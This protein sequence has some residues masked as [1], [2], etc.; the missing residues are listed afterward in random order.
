MTALAHPLTWASPR[1]LW[2]GAAAPGLAPSLLRFASDD[3]MDQLLAVLAVDPGRLAD[4][5]AHYET[6]R[7][8]QGATAD[9]DLIDRVPLAEPLR[10]RRRLT[11][12]ARPPAPAASRPPSPTLKLYQPGHQRYY[13]ACATLACAIPG[14][15]DRK[16][17]G[18]HEQVGFVLRRL[19]P[20]TR[21]AAAGAPLQEYAFVKDAAGARWQRVSADDDAVLAPGEERLPTF[22]L[23]LEDGNGIRRTLWGGL[24]PVGRREDY[25]SAAV[26]RDPK[27]LAEGQQAALAGLAPPP[28]RNSKLART[29]EFRTDFAEG[30]KGLIQ[31]AMKAASDIIADDNNGG[32]PGSNSDNQQLRIRGRNLQFQTHSWLLLLDLWAFL[33]RHLPTVATA[34][35]NQ[36]PAGLSGAKLDLYNW[37]SADQSDHEAMAHGFEALTANP[38]GRPPYA[39]SMAEALR[40]LLVGDTA[41][42][43]EKVETDYTDSPG[44]R[45]P[46]PAFHYLLAGISSNGIGGAIDALGAFRALPGISPGPPD[47]AD[48]A[49][50]T[51]PLTA[52]PEPAEPGPAPFDINL[53]ERLTVLVARALDATD[54]ADARPLPFAQQVAQSMQDSVGDTGR[55]RLR[56]VHLNE[57]CGPLHPPTLSEPTEPFEL[58]SFFDPDAPARPVRIS[59]PMDTSPA[60]LRKH[61][62]GTAFVLSNMLCGQVQRA[63]GHGFVDL[64]RHVLPWPL[65]KEMSVGGGSGGCKNGSV[66]IGMICSLSIPI[67]TLCALILLLMIVAVLDF[68]FRWL[69]WLIFCFPVPGLKGKK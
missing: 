52:P 12:L 40:G 25:M 9:S 7:S 31:S 49:A 65:H 45:G 19:M 58:A 53:V 68:I 11:R 54:E 62:R 2:R 41:A 42:N 28:R 37:L 33:K 61:S 18:G 36:S 47:D 22:P 34:I 60:G 64:V 46:W 59:L 44:E 5:V 66:D 51:I 16:L 26:T 15:P 29:V 17:G 23:A 6:W 32:G 69:P 57:D 67:V 27:P 55:F 35:Q 56:F 13:I 1:P 38:S 10:K 4:H 63:K 3:F 14:L 24:I 50:M 8:P 39:L 21:N 48:V 30:W 43:L 20:A